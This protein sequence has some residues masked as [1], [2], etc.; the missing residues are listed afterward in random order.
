MGAEGTV[1]EQAYQ[2]LCTF[3]TDMYRRVPTSL[4]PARKEPTGHVDTYTIPSS[5][6]IELP[7]NLVHLLH[8]LFVVVQVLSSKYRMKS[9]VSPE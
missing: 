5:E 4:E 9:K 8:L 1:F 2:N 7:L 3:S 6:V